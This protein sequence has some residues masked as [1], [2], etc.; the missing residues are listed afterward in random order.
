MMKNSKACIILVTVPNT[1][2]ANFISETLLDAKLIAAVQNIGKIKSAYFWQGKKV[3]SGEYLLL[4]ITLKKNFKKISQKIQEI[5]PYEVPQIISFDIS[6]TTKEYSDWI[7]E[8]TKGK[9]LK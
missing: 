6:Q 5:H 2:S 9:N 1:K 4:L 3:K 8:N 7:I